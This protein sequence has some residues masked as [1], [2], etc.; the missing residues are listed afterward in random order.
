MVE[1]K[2]NSMLVTL[3][4]AAGEQGGAPQVLV[5]RAKLFLDKGRV[6][7]AEH[8]Y[9]S[10]LT[11]DPHQFWASMGLAQVCTRAERFEEACLHYRQAIAD[12]QTPVDLTY[13]R[14][15]LASSLAGLGELT[16][17]EEIFEQVIREAPDYPYSYTGLALVYETL[18]KPPWEKI[19]ALCEEALKLVPGEAL[20][21]KPKLVNAQARIAHLAMLVE[22]ESGES[23]ENEL[24]V[25]QLRQDQDAAQFQILFRRG[26]LSTIL[27]SHLRDQPLPYVLLLR[28]LFEQVNAAPPD[29]FAS[30]Q[31]FLLFAA[32]FLAGVSRAGDVGQQNVDLEL[33]KRFY[34]L[35]LEGKGKGL[36]AAHLG[37]LKV[38]LRS[39]KFERAEPAVVR[40]VS[41]AGDD[42]AIVAV[43][44][45]V[46]QAIDR[47]AIA[48]LLAAR[49]LEL[50]P[51]PVVEGALADDPLLTEAELANKGWQNLELI[52]DTANNARVA[53]LVSVEDWLAT[54]PA[55]RNDDLKATA[56]DIADIELLDTQI[57]EF[58]ALMGAHNVSL[59][60]DLDYYRQRSGIWHADIDEALLHYF[61]KGWKANLSTHAAFDVTHLRR[62]LQQHRVESSSEPPLLLFLRHEDA[63]GLSPNVLFEPSLY[64]AGL[65][66]VPQHPWFHYLEGGWQQNANISPYFDMT[67]FRKQVR[68]KPADALLPPLIY[69]FT[70]DTFVDV[71]SLFHAGYYDTR[72]REYVKDM[73]PL[74]HFLSE[75]AFLGLQPN[76]FYVPQGKT[77][78]ERLDYLKIHSAV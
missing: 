9:R 56:K 62:Q 33:A 61:E 74:A 57:R 71:N 32:D 1:P 28:Q 40:A 41:E 27:E 55:I 16:Q 75:G 69:Y 66:E 21:I 48:R 76:P 13:A 7:L 63:L 12:A 15:G 31:E 59:L 20:W 25:A 3:Y 39:R 44:A 38:M 19:V 46:M 65:T 52:H 5:A 64:K 49:A 29:R 68:R 50:S 42:P 58:F 34:E 6:D 70:R 17:A 10:A 24:E 45:E 11:A 72:Y 51:Q 22:G 23:G 60:V 35:S 43:S 4:G 36:V 67:R 18:P 78:Q 37:L 26:K 77:V 2:A 8:L 30:L 47:P 53:K 73:A 54:M 14:T